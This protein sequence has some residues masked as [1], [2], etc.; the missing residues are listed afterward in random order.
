MFVFFAARLIGG[1]SN[2]FAAR[3][4][5]CEL[6]SAQQGVGAMPAQQ[7]GQGRIMVILGTWSWRG[8]RET[9]RKARK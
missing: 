6:A 4:G 2:F 7:F 9:R 1:R 5:R 8:G 3:G